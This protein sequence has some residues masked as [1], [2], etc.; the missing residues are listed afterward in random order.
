MLDED[1]AS[2][3]P[4]PR[5]ALDAGCGAGILGICAAGAFA[6]RV[7]AQDRDE[8]ARVFTV[9]NA[10]RNGIRGEALSAHTEPLLSGPAGWDLIL[11]NIPAKAGLTVLE[12]FVLRSAAM[13]NPGGRVC[14]VAVNTLGDFFRDNILKA[15]SA[16]LREE[17]GPGHTVF[18]YS[19]GTAV[20]MA[21]QGTGSA[22]ADF[23]AAHPCYLRNRG[24][25][26][27]E[28]ISYS[29][30]TIHGAPGFDSPGGAVRAAAKLALKTI[31][32]TE[33]RNILVW[34]GDQGHFPSWLAKGFCGA[35][36][37]SF[38]LAGRNI[39]ALEAARRNTLKALG[40]G[41]GEGVSIIPA[42]DLFLDR[43]RLAGAGGPY[44]LIAAFPEAVPGADRRPAFWEA[45]G[46]LA[47]PGGVV[48]IGL[49]SAEA[50]RMDRKKPKNFTPLGGV[51]RE[52][53]RAL[54]YRKRTEERTG[55]R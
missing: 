44:S 18:V 29:L 43:E 6:A 51:R 2:G 7:H 49:S 53:F 47:A 25:Y 4:L 19:P 14:M 16:I 40:R 54:A 45:L 11:S 31:A 10:R 23:L 28:G 50:E 22:A 21:P 41:S 8:L 30:E 17:V 46:L 33:G 37:P 27:M 15:G 9:Y 55:E 26:A 5:S 42:A 35:S 34:E 13:L 36:S 20:P 39:L 38:T 48:L 24:D 12:D 1:E 52:G 3:R 32:P